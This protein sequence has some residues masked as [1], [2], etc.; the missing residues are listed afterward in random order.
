ML[1]SVAGGSRGALVRA[2]VTPAAYVPAR[3]LLKI[4]SQTAQIGGNVIGG[5]LLVVLGTSGA[6][7]V[8]AATFAVSFV[9]RA[10]R[11]RATTER[12]HVVQAG[13]LARLASRRARG[14]RAAR[15]RAAAP[16][17]LARADVLG[18]ARGAR[19]AVR[20][21][22]SRLAGSRRAGGSRRSRSA[23]SPATSSASASCA[24]RSSNGWSSRP[25]Q[26]GFVPYLFFVARS[27]GRRRDRAARRLRRVRDVL[28]RPRRP[29]PRRGARASLRPD[30][31]AEHGGA[32][33]AP[34]ARLRVRRRGRAGDRVGRRDRA[35][36]RLRPG[37][38]RGAALAAP[39]GAVGRL[40]PGSVL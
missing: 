7:L 24:R 33:D 34:G 19:R 18:R 13:V 8:N 9:A 6:I 32:D 4:A 12:R 30:D 39:T 31:G 27:A 15:S 40:R 16:P 36:R 5:A 2:T 21:G 14:L 23:R 11:R 3:S 28:A 1:S 37:G 22:A 25:R 35:R 17:R 26:R 10:A 20:L 38:G 29:H